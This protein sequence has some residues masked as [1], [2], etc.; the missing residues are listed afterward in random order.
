MR[1]ALLH[2]F[3]FAIERMAGK[4]LFLKTKTKNVLSEVSCF[5]LSNLGNN[6]LSSYFDHGVLSFISRAWAY[7]VSPSVF[8]P[9]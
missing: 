5:L 4:G 9:P 6:R 7:C 1:T 8:K 2:N 3:Q